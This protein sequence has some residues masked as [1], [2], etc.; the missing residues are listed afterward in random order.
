MH[1]VNL[2]LPVAMTAVKR[3]WR[4]FYL[5]RSHKNAVKEYCMRNLQNSNILLEYDIDGVIEVGT[6]KID[7]LP[8]TNLS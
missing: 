3:D 5:S 4:R 8:T 7:C 1:K 2:K 6:K